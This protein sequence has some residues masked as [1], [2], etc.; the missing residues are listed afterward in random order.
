MAGSELTGPE[1]ASPELFRGNA[2]ILTPTSASGGPPHEVEGLIEALGATPVHMEAER[3]DR[4]V[5]FVSHLP[6]VVASALMEVASARSR[7]DPGLL[8]LAASGFRGMTR[9]AGSD[10]ELWADILRFNAR[11]VIE[12]VEA[13]LDQLVQ[14]REMLQQGTIDALLRDARAA[15]QALASG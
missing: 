3:H 11:P 2:W 12:A 13:M 4:L 6:Q 1:A 7:A 9:L 14:A 10:P 5:A 8:D 15:R